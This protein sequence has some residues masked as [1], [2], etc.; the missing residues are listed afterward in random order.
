MSALVQIISILF[1]IKI[2]FMKS[3]KDYLK[4]VLL[5]NVVILINYIVIKNYDGAII[6][7]VTILRS[8]LYVRR[9]K[10]KSNMVC[11]AMI[12]LQAL[13]GFLTIKNPIEIVACVS[14]IWSCFY[15]WFFRK[16]MS[17]KLGD[18]L[19]HTSKAVYDG[20]YGLWGLVGM[21]ILNVA[22]V[23]VGILRDIINKKRG[24]FYEK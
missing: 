8:L 6:F 12:A 17:I 9:D 5:A 4:I 3:S 16:P 18:L 2:A 1:T 20:Y 15:M 19:N 11:Y 10:Y 22:I 14:S 23:S 13:V 21:R 24:K 7:S